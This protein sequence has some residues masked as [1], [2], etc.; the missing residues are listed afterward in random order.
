MS[1]SNSFRKTSNT[2][3]SSIKLF[4]NWRLSF[5]HHPP[6]TGYKSHTFSLFN[7][8]FCIGCFA[9]IPS[10]FIGCI[11]SLI[12]LGLE[13]IS[14]KNLVS[15]GIIGLSFQIFSFSIITERKVIKLF[16]KITIGLGSGLILISVYKLLQLDT[17]WRIL[18]LL[19]IYLVG[20]I[21]LQILHILKSKRI[22]NSCKNKWNKEF[23]PTDYCYADTPYQLKEKKKNEINY[24][25]EI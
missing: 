20:N 3:K 10:L 13:I 1:E 6:C 18:I 5:S 15:I 24:Y 23:C 14:A 8:E 11:I 17:I 19:I 25:T 22:C 9:G 16:Q 21:P 7:V 12:L 4:K 2:P